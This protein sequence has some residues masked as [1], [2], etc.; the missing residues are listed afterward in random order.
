MIQRSK[1]P[2]TRKQRFHTR[3][4]DCFKSGVFLWEERRA[5]KN[6]YI[7]KE[8]NTNVWIW[9]RE[10]TIAIELD[11]QPVMVLQDGT[12]GSAGQSRE[13]NPTLS[14]LSISDWNDGVRVGDRRTSHALTGRNL[15]LTSHIQYAY[16]TW[17]SLGGLWNRYG[18]HWTWKHHYNTDVLYCMR[19]NTQSE[20][21]YYTFRVVML[22]LGLL[23]WQS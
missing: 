12:E 18:L 4:W 5:R 9:G 15:H 21:Q 2:E 23:H 13:G 20:L 14:G 8:P 7:Y 19:L 6:F 1:T 3:G 16:A 22:I 10:E 17:L 11:R